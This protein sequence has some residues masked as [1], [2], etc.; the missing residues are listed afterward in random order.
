[1]KKILSL[2]VALTL[3]VFVQAAETN[4]VAFIAN[5]MKI[6]SKQVGVDCASGGEAGTQYHEYYTP[7]NAFDGVSKST[8][9]GDRWLGN[10][11]K[12]HAFLQ[13][14]ITQELA[15]KYIFPLASYE[16]W[17]SNAWP[18]DYLRGPTEWVLEGRNVLGEWVEI[19]RQ[20][21]VS[22]A[23]SPSGGN[24][25]KLFTIPVEK[26]GYYQAFRFTPFRSNANRTDSWDA[27]LMELALN[28]DVAHKNSIVIS[29]IPSTVN[30]TEPKAGEWL[31]PQ[32]GEPLV[33]TAPDTFEQAGVHYILKGYALSTMPYGENWGE[34][35]T[36][37]GSS[38]S[39]Q[40]SDN[41]SARLTWLWK[42][43]KYTVSVVART[44]GTVSTS[45]GAFTLGE[46][47]TATATADPGYRFIRWEGVMPEEQRY[48][49]TI[50]FKVTGVANLEA[51][52]QPLHP[53][54]GLR[55]IDFTITG[56]Q[57]TS[58]LHDFPV[59]V[60]LSHE[61]VPD[62]RYE[63]ASSDGTG[64][65]FVDSNQ[66]VLPFEIER[67]NPQGESLVWVF[68]PVVEPQGT[69]FRMVFDDSRTL[70]DSKAAWSEAGYVGVWHFSEPSGTASDSTS[71]G[72]DAEPMITPAVSIAVPG[73]VG[74][75]RQNA[76]DLECFL[77][78]PYSEDLNVGENFTM[79]GWVYVAP[80][81]GPRRIFSRKQIYTEATGWECFFWPELNGDFGARG[82]GNSLQVTG[83][84]SK[85]LQERW[86]YLTLVYEGNHLSV[87]EDGLCRAS[88][89]I[90]P[91]IDNENGLSIG[92][93]A[94]GNGANGVL[95]GSFDECRY[96]SFVASADRVQAE[97]DSMHD[98]DFLSNDGFVMTGQGDIITVKANPAGF[99]F[100]AATP[101]FGAT[102]EN[103]EAGH[104]YELTAPTGWTNETQTS[105]AVC[106]GWKVYHED[107]SF[108]SG[109]GS[110]LSLVYE[111]VSEV[112]WQ[113]EV[114]HLVSVTPR[115]GEEERDP[116]TRWA[117]HGETISIPVPSIAGAE[118][119]KWT[120]DIGKNDPKAETLSFVVQGPLSI[121]A[122]YTS[123]KS[124]TW[125]VDP[126]GNDNNSGLTSDN[127]FQ[128]IEAALKVATK[129]GDSISLAA[130]THLVKGKL[131]ITNAITVY[132]A[133]TERTILSAF[134]P[135][136]GEENPCRKIHVNHKDAVLRD[137]TITGAV[138]LNDWDKG[139]ALRIDQQGGTVTHCRI[140]EN[141]TDLHF[142][143]GAVALMSSNAVLSFCEIDHNSM[144]GSDDSGGGIQLFD[145][146]VENCLIHHN[147]AFRGGGILMGPAGVVRNCTIADNFAGSTG[148]GIF[149]AGD[150]VTGKARLVNVVFA[151]NQ[152]PNDPGQGAPEWSTRTPDH[153]DVGYSVFEKE[154]QNCLFD[155]A[156][157]VGT[158]SRAGDPAFVAP[159]QG[160]YALLPGSAAIDMGTSYEGIAE[161]D[162]KGANRIQGEGVDAGCH[163]FQSGEA[164]CGFSVASRELFEGESLALAPSVY[165]PSDG[166]GFAYEWKLTS[167]DGESIVSTDKTSVIP[168]QK[169]GWYDVTLTALRNDGTTYATLN[170][171][172]YIHV[173]ARTNY[174]AVAGDSESAYPWKTPETASSDLHELLEESIDGSVIIV[175]PG[176]YGLTD[177]AMVDKGVAIRGAGID[178]STFVPADDKM[179]KRL[180][181]LNHPDSLLMGVTLKGAH[182]NG[183]LAWDYGIAAKIGNR[184]GTMRKCR[185]TASCPL[186]I[187]YHGAVGMTGERGL[188]QDC[189]IDH[190]TNLFNTGCGG[191]LSMKAGLAERCRILE[192]YSAGTSGGVCLRLKSNLRNSL[193]SGNIAEAG[194]A[195]IEILEEGSL[196][197]C[198][199]VGNESRGADLNC[200]GAG[201]LL[202]G[203]NSYQPNILNCI[204]AANRAPNVTEKGPGWPEWYLDDTKS[205]MEGIF[206]HC[207]FS[208]SAAIGTDALTGDPLFK[209]PARGNFALRMS[210]PARDKG[211][212]E[213]WMRNSTDLAG[214][215]RVDRKTNVDLGCFECCDAACTLLLIR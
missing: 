143:R 213:E 61:R 53:I 71:H 128:T 180:F 208:D 105:R 192:N 54:G 16:V 73:V 194:G 114:S 188:L 183:E 37:K 74:D 178:Q 85:S 106:T 76:T 102:I 1:M 18:G 65:H 211:L 10:M 95:V 157:V 215:P 135:H 197:N 84:F 141:H 144:A 133:G 60:R 67:W 199:I 11:A 202:D 94:V 44:G 5:E 104:R 142:L 68:L 20:Q 14:D 77:A 80:S 108:T 87:Y 119:F 138:P 72:L 117:L 124:N 25:G 111:K 7:A 39:F 210:S 64:F 140:T 145:G 176:E 49:E 149:W 89:E 96:S 146:I 195:G 171:P 118:F 31:A 158:G 120:G 129:A 88:G 15:D 107:G 3:S 23:A 190:N 82:A 21:D 207:L 212:F 125:Y 36:N 28:V 121:T 164:A 153:S 189:L 62:F 116:I 115:V 209:N 8:S 203:N 35:V 81:S 38:Y 170:R 132:G 43:D 205:E 26:R 22:W 179:T 182:Q 99:D 163:E 90:T 184:G 58:Q 214:K 193:I 100:G 168:I 46:T 34:V 154:A 122:T 166:T 27:G 167:R 201:I 98:P 48:Q 103:A 70:V 151:R 130:G 136:Y 30:C 59:L 83:T 172:S 69:S 137:V 86:T 50:S 161:L 181:F 40:L 155:G 200:S 185:V 4:L 47:I 32:N 134:P 24:E 91:A 6:T 93:V 175:L 78:V 147:Q 152:A 126:D 57:G 127:P 9:T 52:F 187:S 51:V 2:L 75:G 42:A 198:T 162:F 165:G 63:D 131:E 112:E 56:Y 17:D 109:T 139:F 66:Q 196:V 123:L 110:T 92:N 79:S 173:A 169:A 12:A 55:H 33:C 150:D 45:G 29:S 177:T 186:H 191:G 41:C 148:G 206:R 156:P 204:F 159:D 13:F 174:L 113:Y 97:Y 160:N 19:D 101:P